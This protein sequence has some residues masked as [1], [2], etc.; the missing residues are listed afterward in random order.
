MLMCRRDASNIPGCL[1]TPHCQWETWPDTDSVQQLESLVFFL[2]ADLC[3]C[4]SKSKSCC[5][6]QMSM[7]AN[8]KGLRPKTEAGRN[9][10]CPK[11]GFGVSPHR[12]SSC[13]VQCLVD[14]KIVVPLAP[15]HYMPAE[16]LFIKRAHT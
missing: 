1:A 6:P 10:L 2:F 3:T 5:S 4:V 13:F 7:V 12:H 8:G 15:T 16:A 11:I 14:C 9:T